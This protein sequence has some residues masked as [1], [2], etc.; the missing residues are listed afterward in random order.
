MATNF[1]QPG[2]TITV[3]APTGGVTSGEGVRIG[4]LFGVALST[5]AQGMPVEIAT[6]GV[7]VLPKTSALAIDVGD[8]VYWNAANGVVNKTPSSQP[9][10]GIAVSDAVN[11]S[12]TVRVKLG[13]FAANAA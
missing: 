5:A 2:S 7:F 12:P 13:S 10:V 8:I 9:V 1:V 3:A 6:E 4:N 11:P